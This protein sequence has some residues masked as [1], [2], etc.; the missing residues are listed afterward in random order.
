[1][2]PADRETASN[3]ETL[4]AKRKTVLWVSPATG[5][6]SVAEGC[7]AYVMGSR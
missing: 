2:V 6:R 4:H 3:Q 7:I 1:M 5:W